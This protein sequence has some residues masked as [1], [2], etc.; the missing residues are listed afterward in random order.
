MKVTTITVEAGRTFNHPYENYGNLR[1]ALSITAQLEEGEDW[2]ACA[3]TL[4]AQAEAQ[5]E[6]HKYALLQ[7]M[8][9]LRQ[10]GMKVDSPEAVAVQITRDI[11][12]VASVTHLLEQQRESIAELV[13]QHP[14]IAEHLGAEDDL[15]W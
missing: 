8:K 7:T 13:K 4:Q 14:E 9:A 5:I 2:E 6:M 10:P 11:L 15:P 3:R 1:P 12:A